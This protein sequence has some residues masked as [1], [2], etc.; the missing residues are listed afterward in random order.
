MSTHNLPRE[1]TSFVGRERE[2]SELARLLDSAQLLTLVGT[3]GAGKTRLALRLAESVHRHYADGVWVVELAPLAEAPQIWR[4]VAAATGVGE[5]AG[6]LLLHTLVQALGTQ[7]LLL[8]LDNCEHVVDACAELT[9]HLLRACDRLRVLATSREPL[10]VDGEVLF[11]VPPLALPAHDDPEALVISEAGRLFV[12]RARAV[13]PSFALGDATSASVAQVCRRLDGLPLAIELAAARVEAL[14]PA[15][16][17]PRLEDSFRVLVSGGRRRPPRQQTLRAAVTWSYDLLTDGEQ[18]LFERLSVFGGGFALEGAEAVGDGDTLELLPRLVAK[19]M[20][21]AEPQED[22]TL[23]YRLLEPLRQ[24]ARER[25]IARGDLEDARHRHAAYM[26]ILGDRAVSLFNSSV[27]VAGFRRLAAEIDNIRAAHD[28]TVEAHDAQTALRMAA[29]F[30]WFWTQPDRQAEGRIRLAQA[31]RLP[32]ANAPPLLRGR[33][34]A[35]L[36]LLSLLQGDVPAAGTLG[37]EAL[38]IERKHPDTALRAVVLA[39]QGGVALFRGE[40]SVAEGPF[41]EALAL[42]RQA[43]LSMLEIQMLE[44]LT[45]V[46][47]ARG[48]LTAAEAHIADEI[49]AARESDSVWGQAMALNSLGDVRRVLGEYRSAGAAYEE[50][51]PLFRLLDSR[52]RAPPGTLHN[53]AYV[54]L[55]IGDARRA[56]ELF[57]EAAAQYRTMGS[58]QRGVAECVMGL[59][60]AAIHAGVPESGARLFGAAEAALEALGTSFTPA[61]VADYERNL[62]VLRAALD[63]DRVGVQWAA[64][65]AMSLE[66]AL[67]AARAALIEATPTEAAAGSQRRPTELTVR[68][69]EVALLLTRGLSNRQIAAELVISERTAANHV[70]RVMDKLD[71]HSRAQLAARSAELGL[72]TA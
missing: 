16:L 7:E 4:A 35:A 21:Q 60:G 45:Q 47:M 11:R 2:L 33:V 40:L 52:G 38:E 9:D 68:E 15:E 17:A 53:L 43:E 44:N 3:G 59:A 54:A 26:L 66:E 8:V 14:A 61:N 28:W 70:Q 30:W 55:G 67:G 24:F 32:A 46:A 57:L 49:A 31:L 23:R 10:G 71:V 69:Q 25:L 1:L 6:Q 13:Q 51:L 37:A 42:A 63:A 65:R 41:V 62:A 72:H 29:A 50:A 20:V 56:A 64:G 36:G 27:Q 18:R 34:V 22:D 48:D 5:Q 12:E 39:T 58:D 19:S